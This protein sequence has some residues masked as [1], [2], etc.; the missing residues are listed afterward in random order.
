MS[1]YGELCDLRNAC[2]HNRPL[3]GEKFRQT[4]EEKLNI[5]LAL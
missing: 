2:H 5:R 4:I 1:G 3:G